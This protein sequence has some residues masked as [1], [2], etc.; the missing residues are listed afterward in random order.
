M[1]V[2]DDTSGTGRSARVVDNVGR[3]A[4]ESIA[5]HYIEPNAFNM[6]GTKAEKMTKILPFL[7]NAPMYIG[8]YNPS[9]ARAD[10]FRFITQNIE[11]AISQ[12]KNR[13]AVDWFL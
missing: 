12:E 1:K 10:S 11:Q 8:Y 4:R 2:Y 7:T 13:N 6:A 9:T 3:V 5:E